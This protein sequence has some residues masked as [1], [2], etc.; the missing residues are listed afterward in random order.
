LFK[1][2]DISANLN[3]VDLAKGSNTASL[4]V[5][6]SKKLNNNLSANI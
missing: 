3:L 5:D 1:E 6:Y 4:G 2:G